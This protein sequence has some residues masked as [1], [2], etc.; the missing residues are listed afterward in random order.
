METTSFIQIKELND[1]A[2]KLRDEFPDFYIPGMQVHPA[3]P[4]E[5]CNEIDRCCG[6]EGVRWVGE[7]VGYMMG[8][9]DEFASERALMIMNK[10]LEY[11]AVA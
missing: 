9:A 3:F 2:L 8:Y 6:Q 1:A 4:D 5:S 11:D 7:L 10:A